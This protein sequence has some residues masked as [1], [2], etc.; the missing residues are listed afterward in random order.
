[1]HIVG[2]TAIPGGPGEHGGE[3][4]A[5]GTP[6]NSVG[7]WK[8]PSAS[9][10]LLGGGQPTQLDSHGRQPVLQVPPDG[11]ELAG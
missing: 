7:R 2:H 8:N 1:M 10:P 3:A 4:E 9:G 11:V 5:V 6:A